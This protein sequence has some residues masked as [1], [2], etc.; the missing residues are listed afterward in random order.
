MSQIYQAES[1][2][3]FLWKTAHYIRYGY[4]RYALRSIPEGKDVAAIGTKLVLFYDVTYNRNLRAARRKKGI[5]NV[6]ILQFKNDFLLLASEGSHANFDKID[7]LDF[8]TKPLYFSGYT[9]GIQQQKPSIQIAPRRFKIIRKRV[10]G[11]A[12]HQHDKVTRIMKAISPF[13]FK[14]VSDQRWKIINEVNRRRKKAGLKRID[15]VE[16]KSWKA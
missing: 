8:K 3:E 16:V 6:V 12:L 7:S 13:S 10:Q 14:G 2:G 5:A 11:V 4:T 9:I 15:W 1:L